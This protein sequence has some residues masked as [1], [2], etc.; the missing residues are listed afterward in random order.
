MLAEQRS[1]GV[2]SFAPWERNKTSSWASESR[3]C[4]EPQ[5]RFIKRVGRPSRLCS[6]RCCRREQGNLT[7]EEERRR[8]LRIREC[9]AARTAPTEEAVERSLARTEASCAYILP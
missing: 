3:T 5:K 1:F 7:A 2:R 6:C 4:S 8:P 9:R